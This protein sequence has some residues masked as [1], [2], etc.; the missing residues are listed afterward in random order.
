[1]NECDD[2]CTF[3]NKELNS[4]LMSILSSPHQCSTT[5]FRLMILGTYINSH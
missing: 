3:A 4:E 5:T 2:Q 1:M